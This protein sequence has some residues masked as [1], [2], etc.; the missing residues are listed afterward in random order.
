MMRTRSTFFCQ[1]NGAYLRAERSDPTSPL[2]GASVGSGTAADT[3][4]DAAAGG[5][6]WDAE[7]VGGEANVRCPTLARATA[8]AGAVNG[9]HGQGEH[10]ESAVASGDRGERS[11][12]K[13]SVGGNERKDANVHDVLSAAFGRDDHPAARP[14]GVL[15]TQRITY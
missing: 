3:G 11:M 9:R 14:G 15:R 6:K 13:R 12:P 2:Y 8:S 1:T 10:R 5:A 7:D 4:D